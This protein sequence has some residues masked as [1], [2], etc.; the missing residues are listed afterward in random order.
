MEYLSSVFP[1]EKINQHYVI[2]SFQEALVSL[3]K[4]N[5]LET[6]ENILKT[7]LCYNNDYVQMIAFNIFRVAQIRPNLIPY[8]VDVCKFLIDRQGPDNSL[9]L[10]KDLIAPKDIPK[11]RWYRSFL[12]NCINK[13]VV[14]IEEFM[15]LLV[16]YPKCESLYLLFC[17]FAPVIESKDENLF[18]TLLS[19]FMNEKNLPQEFLSFKKDFDEMRKNNWSLQRFYFR[20]GYYEVSFGYY[21][22]NDDLIHLHQIISKGEFVT[23]TEN[24]CANNNSMKK[25]LQKNDD[26]SDEEEDDENDKQEEIDFDFDQRVEDSLFERCE[27][28]RHRPTLLQF[29]AFFG[30]LKCFKYL[31]GC[32]ADPTITDDEGKKLIQFVVANGSEEIFQACEEYNSKKKAKLIDLDGAIQTAVEFQRFDLMVYLLRKL[33]VKIDISTNAFP[34][35]FHYAAMHDNMQVL[36]FCL[37]EG[38]DVNLQDMQKRTPLHYA[39]KN[40]MYDT[41]L[42]LIDTYDLDV[43]AA[44]A[45]GRT[46][47]HIATKYN[48]LNSIRI[49][50]ICNNIDYSPIDVKGNSPLS[51]AA[52]SG[53]NDIVCF[54]LSQNIDVNQKNL[55]GLSPLHFA[56][57]KGFIQTVNL[58]LSHPQI[59]VNI[60]DIILSNI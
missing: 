25:H 52:K 32:G 21:I 56:V 48:Q 26:S 36:F 54:L 23:D 43:N 19:L 29:A 1:E 39:A 18:N 7:S 35:V 22:K 42:A 27:F 40:C 12:I 53:N 13:H 28:V 57:K 24:I 14:T 17:W 51:L 8:L 30:A 55:L 33:N 20:N 46:P 10:L 41:L 38:C 6:S 11:Q 9:W 47:L 2:L 4:D 3:N 31:L 5:V 16:S 49:L 50:G 45:D 59:D 58:L 44:D 34:S 60:C 15:N 37:N